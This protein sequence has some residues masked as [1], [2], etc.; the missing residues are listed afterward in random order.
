MAVLHVKSPDG[1]D[2][3]MTIVTTGTTESLQTNGWC[4]LPNGLFIQW[5]TWVPDTTPAT[6]PSVFTYPIK[7]TTFVG[8]ANCVFNG[9]SL[10][11]LI[12]VDWATGEQMSLWLWDSHTAA[13]DLTI[14]FSMI[15]LCI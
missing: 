14:R 8:A 13:N 15:I 2:Y 1:T 10:G 12:V 4:Q 9:Y 7:T 3:N 11:E 6:N 5:L